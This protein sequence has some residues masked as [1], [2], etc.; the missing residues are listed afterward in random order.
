MCVLTTT[1]MS[2]CPI[3]IICSISIFSLL[4]ILLYSIK[5]HIT[6][7]KCASQKSII[8]M[9]CLDFENSSQKVLTYAKVFVGFNFVLNSLMNGLFA[10]VFIA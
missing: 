1:H 2:Y 3:Y 5:R 4:Q 8:Q 10:D 6:S 7:T 9:I